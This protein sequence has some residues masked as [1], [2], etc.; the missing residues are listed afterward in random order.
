MDSGQVTSNI[1]KLKKMMA[2]RKSQNKVAS[3]KG[4]LSAPAEASPVQMSVDEAS[5]AIVTPMTGFKFGVTLPQGRNDINDV[6]DDDNFLAFDVEQPRT[7]PAATEQQMKPPLKSRLGFP[8]QSRP[9]SQRLG[10]RIPG[11]MLPLLPP[12]KHP[13]SGRLGTRSEPPHSLDPPLQSSRQPPRG[14][15]NRSLISQMSSTTAGSRKSQRNGSGGGIELPVPNLIE[16]FQTYDIDQMKD[17]AEKFSDVK[18]LKR[19]ARRFDEETADELVQVKEA[20]RKN[21]RF[22][23]FK[24][25]EDDDDDDDSDED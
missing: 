25:D 18:T 19:R 17:R 1:L 20:Q 6:L 12:P 8:M 4:S 7:T 24:L 14:L 5:S 23:R 2:V 21:L 11:V 22:K 3:I 15:S 9:L 10:T 16:C 13:L